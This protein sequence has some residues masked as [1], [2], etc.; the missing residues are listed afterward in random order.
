MHALKA[1]FKREFL[2]YFRTPVGYVFMVIFLLAANGSLFFLGNFFEGN[3]ASLQAFFTFHPWLYLFL[4]PAV[5]M[6]LW[7]EERREGTD[8]LLFT[9]PISQGQAI[10]AKFLAA[11]LFVGL[12]ILL[13]L[14]LVAT[15]N[16]L[17]EPDNGII[18]T[19]YFGSFLMA[20]AYLAIASLTS[21]LTKNQVIAF[22]LGVIICFVLVLMGWGV[23]TDLMANFLPAAVIHMVSLFGFMSHYTL[24]SA[25]V[26]EFRD[27]LYFAS[28]IIGGLLLTGVVLSSRRLA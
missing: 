14:P 11:W 8:E 15:V 24:M 21:A 27:L 7:A 2:G 26:I 28:M 23:F 22:V 17:G 19:G 25:G 13:T 1:L 4:V 12:G 3:Q 20:G 5:G 6:R 9:L 18:F 10:A 16:Y